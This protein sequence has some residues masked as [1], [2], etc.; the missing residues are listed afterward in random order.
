L[1]KVTIVSILRPSRRRDRAKSRRALQKSL[2]FFP[3]CASFDLRRTAVIG[4]SARPASASR[5]AKRVAMRFRRLIH[6][7]LG[8]LGLLLVGCAALRGPEPLGP[9][10]VSPPGAI[11]NTPGN[12]P[13][14]LTPPAVNLPGPAPAFVPQPTPLEATP[15]QPT[16]LQPVPTP[17]PQP[18]AFVPQVNPVYMQVVAPTQGMAGG[19]LT[20]RVEIQNRG[21][22][23]ARGVTVASPVAQGLTFLSSNPN[24]AVAGQ[25]L[26]WS[27]GDLPGYG[28]AAVQINFR[29]ETAGTANFCAD[30]GI[31]SGAVLRACAAT[32]IAGSG[33]PPAPGPVPPAPG[34]A[35]TAV[36]SPVEVTMSGPEQ[37]RLDEEVEFRITITNRGT[38]KATGL[39]LTDRYD[40]GLVHTKIK[41]EQAI[42]RDVPEIPPGESKVIRVTFRVTRAG[43]LCNRAVVTGAGG[44][45]ASAEACVTV[46]GIPGL[47]V[48]MT[49]PE[50][51]AVGGKGLFR[52]EV[53]NAGDAD[54][55]GLSV[56]SRFDL[57]LNPTQATQFG[58][59]QVR[60]TRV[61]EQYE[62]S[63]WRFDR[64][65][66]GGTMVLEVE[67]Q[68][69][70]AAA[71]A[72]G[73]VTVAS[74]EVTSQDATACT[75]VESVDKPPPPMMDGG[76]GP[77]REG[78]LSLKIG[79]S[80]DPA[81][82][83]D[84][85]TYLVTVTNNG[86]TSVTDLTV[87]LTVS[88]HLSPPR[89][90]DANP[91]RSTI[92]GRTIGFD[93]A[94]QLRAGESLT[95]RVRVQALS[96]GTARVDAAVQAMG[97]PTLR[98]QKT[99]TVAAN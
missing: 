57:P 24:P 52:L 12:V 94:P 86:R 98:E 95:Y 31:G 35:P 45:S 20:Y 78:A 3:L 39:V 81:R 71:R 68:G 32:P 99:T 87:Q 56:A 25:Q 21:G 41:G 47:S 92:E 33:V 6:C 26:Q 46:T 74:R 93:P 49:A 58:G 2:T 38:T 90:P 85:I 51:I 88:S 82:V 8:C 79:S 14:R 60:V 61:G 30:V 43:R 75:R 34:P 4:R 44:L 5:D 84:E 29:A 80:S 97:V 11:I 48:R 67:C 23:V 40:D 15:L 54:L 66:A 59:E 83:G 53:H 50:S 17:V 76:A 9:T 69:E 62:L 18:Q 77:P 72:C 70:R 73:R 22:D 19:T 91:A 10:Y 96:A 37:A 89:A 55:T 28:A 42:E 16:P 36:I 65:A 13:A 7:Q 64:L 1:L 63:P 27:L